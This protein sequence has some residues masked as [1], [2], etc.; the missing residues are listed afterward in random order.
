MMATLKN[1]RRWL[2]ATAACGSACILAACSA[3]PALEE[4]SISGRHPFPTRT[5]SPGASAHPIHGIDV[6]KFQGEIDWAALKRAGVKFAFIK[7]TEGADR[8]DDRFSQNWQAARAAGIA[9]GAYHFNY[10]CSAIE[11]QIAWYQRHVPVERDSLPPILDLE[12]NR[13]SPTC[14]QKFPKHVVVPR[15]KA[16]LTAMERHYGKKPIIYVDGPFYRDVLSGGEFADY[17]MWLSNM[18]G[19]PQEKFP[20]RS[21]AFWQY[22]Y[23][24]QL[25]GIRG[26]VDRNVFAGSPEQWQKLAASG[27]AGSGAP[28]AEVAAGPPARPDPKAPETPIAVAAAEASSLPTAAPLPPGRPDAA[29]TGLAP[30]SE[31]PPAAAPAN[32]EDTAEAP[33]GKPRGSGSWFGW[34]LGDPARE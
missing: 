1:L 9:R 23:R 27:F 29:A 22:T 34:L 26:R 21:W 10:W 16:W 12:W 2:A 8:L 5:E 7:A 28:V 17:P 30:T 31:A 25:P 4:A 14:P 3:G 19:L 24:G 18:R 11:D 32:P 20:G 6:A 15:I 13:H 33:A